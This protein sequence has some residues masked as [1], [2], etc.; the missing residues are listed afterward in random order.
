MNF[1]TFKSVPRLMIETLAMRRETAINH[2]DL[3][4]QGVYLLSYCT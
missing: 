3:Q 1:S 4:L 2:R